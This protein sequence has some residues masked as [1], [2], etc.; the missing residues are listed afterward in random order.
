MEE[1]AESV[2]A[3]DA[4]DDQ[5]IPEASVAVSPETVESMQ[6]TVAP[7]D[8]LMAVMEIWSGVSAALAE[9]ATDADQQ[10]GTIPTNPGRVALV[11]VETAQTRGAASLSGPTGD[12]ETAMQSGPDLEADAGEDVQA[13]DLRPARTTDARPGMRATEVPPPASQK[14]A[15]MTSALPLAELP[16][17]T[18]TQSSLLSG[19]S[20][21]A[22]ISVNPQSE[23]RPV[24]VAPPIVLRQIADAVVTTRKDRIEITLSPEELGRVRLVVTGPE[25]APHVTVW[26][27][28]PE[29]MD[30][31]RRNSGLLLQHFEEAG[32]ENSV[33]EF[34]DGGNS[35]SGGEER[36]EW[37]V[38][39]STD[40]RVAPEIASIGVAQA[41]SLARGGLSGER[42]ID[43][44]L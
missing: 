4:N 29:V 10:A 42:R 12:G 31:V 14:P 35:D 24:P 40:G 3:P 39:P 13:A 2:E 30:L 34:R 25:R 41:I 20:D 18:A 37:N 7:A 17:A 15:A 19:T 22:Q 32:L 26:I 1:M 43:I 33:F 38:H 27:E 6:D 5:D 23:W 11:D 44:R 9:D 36:A 28:R 16:S 21:V 8:P